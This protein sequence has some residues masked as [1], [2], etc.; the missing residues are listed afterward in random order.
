MQWKRIDVNAGSRVCRDGRVVLA[1]WQRVCERRIRPNSA[2]LQ[3][4]RRAQQGR[5]PHE[6]NAESVLRGVFLRCRVHSIRER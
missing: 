6:A 1:H 2:H 4:Q 5:I 3:Q